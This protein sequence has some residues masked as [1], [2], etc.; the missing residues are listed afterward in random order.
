MLH[1]CLRNNIRG[2]GVKMPQLVRYDEV[3]E[4]AARADVLLTKQPKN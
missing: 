2:S 3:A 1:P 4:G